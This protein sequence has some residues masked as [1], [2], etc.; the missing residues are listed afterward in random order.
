MMWKEFQ[1]AKAPRN[2]HSEELSVK[3]CGLAEL[4]HISGQLLSKL[5]NVEFLKTGKAACSPV[6][7]FTQE[8]IRSPRQA[9]AICPSGTALSDAM[10]REA[11]AG[12]G[13]VVELG[14]GTGAVTKALLKRGIAPENIVAVEQSAHLAN[15]LRNRFPRVKVVQEDASRLS[16]LFYGKAID[17]VVSSLPLVS[18]PPDMRESIMRQIRRLAAGKRLIQFT[19]FWGDSYLTESGFKL[20][21]TK[22]VFKNFPPARVMTFEI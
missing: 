7:A 22:T 17:S 2:K 19:Y 3:N 18:L 21:H 8:I 15:F 12:D 1:S 10:A 4:A 5:G 6:V 9:G 20:L 11:V 14:A 13:L 16:E